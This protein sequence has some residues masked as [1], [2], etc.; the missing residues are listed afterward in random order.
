MSTDLLDLKKKI[1][2]IDDIHHKKILEIFLKHNI[3]VSENRNGCFINI[4]NLS[5]EIQKEITEFLKYINKQ[6]KTLNDVEKIKKKYKKN[7]FSNEEK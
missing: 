4:S 3:N 2:N 1:E 7:F 6:E 5:P